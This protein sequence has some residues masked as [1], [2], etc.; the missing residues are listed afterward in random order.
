MTHHSENQA[1]YF[2]GFA[3]LGAM[4]T[5]AGTAKI[6]AHLPTADAF[7]GSICGSSAD[8]SGSMFADAV[9]CWGCPA[10][11]LG[12][13]LLVATTIAARLRPAGT[14]VLQPVR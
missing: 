5:A 4:L 7:I 14:L 9:H 6:V 8:V 13:A 3:G 1:A 12:V 11:A 10:A 2:M